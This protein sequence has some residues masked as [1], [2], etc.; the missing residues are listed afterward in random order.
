LLASGGNDFVDVAGYAAK[1]APID[2]AEDVD[3][4]S[5]VVVGYYRHSCSALR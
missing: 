1:I 4:R 2:R 3:D 5:N